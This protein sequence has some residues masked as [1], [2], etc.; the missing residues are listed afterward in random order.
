MSNDIKVK[1]TALKKFLNEKGYDVKHTECIEAVSRIETGQFY[2]VAKND[3]VRILKDGEKL[4]FK[5][6]KEKDF[7]VDVVIPMEMDVIMEG[8]EAVNDVASETI[9]GSDYALCDISY[10]TFPYHYGNSS[11][12]VRVTGYI[13]EI[14]TLQHLDDYEEQDED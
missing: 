10:E 6:L 13:E 1:A 4:S 3:A 9:T 7:Q 5:E 8:I 11:V 14:E 12:A 2:N